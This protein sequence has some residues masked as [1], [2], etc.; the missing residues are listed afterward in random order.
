MW[1]TEALSVFFVAN[2]CHLLKN[3]L[4]KKLC[5]KFPVLLKNI[6]QKMKTLL[7]NHQVFTQ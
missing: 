1:G 2:F 3:I 4:E 6:R 7:K 5:H